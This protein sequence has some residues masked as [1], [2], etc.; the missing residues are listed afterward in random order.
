M[1]LRRKPRHDRHRAQKRAARRWRAD[2]CGGRLCKRPRRYRAKPCVRTACA[3]CRAS[4]RVVVGVARTRGREKRGV[5]R[6]ALGAKKK[7]VGDRKS[8]V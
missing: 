3:C 1:L 5:S 6:P 2:R 7:A 8:V 4:Q